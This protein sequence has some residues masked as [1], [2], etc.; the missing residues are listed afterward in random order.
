MDVAENSNGGTP[1][2]LAERIARVNGPS[3]DG[4]NSA[5]FARELQGLSRTGDAEG[6]HIL[7]IEL[8]RWETSFDGIGGPGQ[9]NAPPRSTEELWVDVLVNLDTAAKLADALTY[10]GGDEYLAYRVVAE[11]GVAAIGPAQK[12]YRD[13]LGY[14][15]EPPAVNPNLN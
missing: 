12:F 5:D 4:I 9:P 11:G 15:P 13:T 14:W 3:L 2:S 6:L 10:T 8:A 7:L 1:P